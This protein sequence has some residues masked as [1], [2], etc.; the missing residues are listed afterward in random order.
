VHEHLVERF[1]LRKQ[2]KK[3]FM[4]ELCS[5]STRECFGGRSQNLCHLH[6]QVS[7]VLRDRRRV[8][9][10]PFHGREEGMQKRMR[11]HARA[12]RIIDDERRQLAKAL[13]DTAHGEHPQVA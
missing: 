11:R 8:L 9:Q 1:V 6:Q 10:H 13:T 7:G 12:A 3:E 4:S 5:T 2:N